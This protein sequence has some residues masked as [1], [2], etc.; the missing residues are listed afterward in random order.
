M[1][2]GIKDG[3]MPPKFLL[4]KVPGQCDG[5]I[6]ANPFLQ[7]TKK[8]PAEFS[9]QDKKQLTDEITNAVNEDVFPAYNKF[10]EFVRTDYAPTGRTELSIESLPDGKRR[11]AEA[12]KMMTTINVTP[13]EVHDIGLKEVD[14][15]TAEMT[16]LAQA[17]G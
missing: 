3:L 5:V 6:K 4:E 11:Y 7:P 8:F 13:A 15:I 14:R 10:A 12:I 9:E 2:Q 17:Q 1:R 16:R